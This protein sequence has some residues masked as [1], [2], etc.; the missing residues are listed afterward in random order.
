MKAAQVIMPTTIAVAIWLSSFVLLS[1]FCW[2]HFGRLVKGGEMQWWT[3][4]F[5]SAL[6]IALGALAVLMSA[7]QLAWTVYE[8]VPRLHHASWD[9]GLTYVSALGGLGSV[10]LAAILSIGLALLFRRAQWS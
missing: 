5:L 7:V 8:N 3:A 6:S 4:T 1:L 9:V 10:I 2:V